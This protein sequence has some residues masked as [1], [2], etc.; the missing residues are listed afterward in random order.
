[1][2]TIKKRTKSGI[3]YEQ[4]SD[5]IF[6][7]LGLKD[8]DELF[9]RGMLAI[10]IKKIL[11]ERGLKKQKDI[12]ELWG[13]D[14]TDVS[15]FM[16]ADYQRFSQERLLSFLNKLNYKVT[17]QIAPMQKGDRPQEVVMM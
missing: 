5:N 8:A 10:Q 17:M 11:I 6:A 9:A 13:I 7:D 4:G 15:K 1:M 14:K 16:N 3:E 2:A 12:A